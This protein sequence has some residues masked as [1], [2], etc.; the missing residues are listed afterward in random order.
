[1]DKIDIAVIPAA[2]LGTRLQPLSFF[3]PKEML[4]IA[5]FPMIHYSVLEAARVGCSEIALITSKEKES[6][7]HYVQWASKQEDLS[8]LKFHY[9]YQKKPTGISD[10]ILVAEDA[11]SNQPFIVMYPDDIFLPFSA[12][13]PL[14]QL[15]KVFEEYEEPVIGMEEFEDLTRILPYGNIRGEWFDDSKTIFKVESIKEKPRIEEVTT[16][17]GTMGRYILFPDIFNY[18]RQL[19]IV[20]GEE[21]FAT[22]ALNNYAKE[23]T[24]LAVPLRGVRR[25]DAGNIKDYVKT[26][27][28]AVEHDAEINR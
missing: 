6:L 18:F 21:R 14:E 5:G 23:K 26:F 2:G 13:T 11:V 24:L 8:H 10:A 20:K 9:L 22:D 4:P 3:Y 28:A 27:V 17:F 19:P 12:T 15:L 7:R 16:P 1:M 25:Y